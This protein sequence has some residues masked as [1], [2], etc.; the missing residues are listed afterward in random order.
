MA[1]YR[2]CIISTLLYGS[3]LDNTCG[4][5]KRLD[6]FD[7]R[8]LRR[9][10]SIFWQDR[11]TNSAVL[12]RA[13]IPSIYTLLR[14][15]R[16]WWICHVRPMDEGRIPKE[17]LYGELAQGKRPVRRSKLRFKDVAK[18]SLHAIGLPIYSWETLA[19]DRSAWRTSC[20]E[21]LREGE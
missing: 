21:A 1:V 20:T 9:I 11:I 2:G 12:E 8:C 17:L 3:V 6:L 14:Q 13:G 19:S 18:R 7:L 16:L 15:R 10:L 5:G 4:T